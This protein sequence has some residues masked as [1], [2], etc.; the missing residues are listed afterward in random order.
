MLRLVLDVLYGLVGL[1]VE[2]VYCGDRNLSHPVAQQ[3]ESLVEQFNPD[4]NRKNKQ[5]SKEVWGP[6]LMKSKPSDT[7]SAMLW[8]YLNFQCCYDACTQTGSCLLRLSCRLCVCKTVSALLFA[9][10]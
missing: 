2:V 3:L 5:R 9:P 1:V 4:Y 8:Q 6:K 7:A 10:S